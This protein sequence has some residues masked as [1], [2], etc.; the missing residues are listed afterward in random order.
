MGATPHY[1]PASIYLFSNLRRGITS[2]TGLLLPLHYWG[3]LVVA[4]HT[5]MDYSSSLP[6]PHWNG[7]LILDWATGYYA[8]P[9]K[10]NVCQVT[11]CATG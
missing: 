8:A 2:I 5:G 9:D 7:P 10:G 1:L 4:Y 3:L 6:V 11:P